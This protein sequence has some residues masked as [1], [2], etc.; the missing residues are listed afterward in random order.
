V[1]TVQAELA[2]ET[3]VDVAPDRLWQLLADWDR[4]GEW[5]PCTRVWHVD[6]PPLGVGT[7]IAARTG[8]GPV[9]FVDTMTLTSV[10]APHR[11]EVVHTGRVIKGVGAFMVEADRGRARFRWW[12][13]VD[14][15]GGPLGRPLWWVAGP[16]S[17][18]LLGWAMGRLRRLAEGDPAAARP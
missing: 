4:H 10:D 3:V 11:Y 12:E 18:L 17:R 5:M 6:G 16:L 15:P 9:G 8:L 13:R 1:T 7:R 2:V 14:L